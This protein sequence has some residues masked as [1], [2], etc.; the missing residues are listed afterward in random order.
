[1]NNLNNDSTQFDVLAAINFFFNDDA[2]KIMSEQISTNPSLLATQDV[3]RPTFEHGL[4]ELV[5]KEK[6]D[7]LIAELNLYGSFKKIPEDL[8]QTFFITE[9]KMAWN[10]ETRSYRSIGPIGIGSID[11]VSVN[12]KVNGYVEVIHKRTGDVLNIYLEPENGKWFYFSYARG[13]MQALS[14]VTT[15]NDVITKLKPEKRINKEKDKPDFEY[16][17]STD[18]AVKNFLKRMQPAVNEEEK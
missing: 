15:F 2:I 13:L 9:L 17:L 1:M 12:R 10:N 11:K 3:G 6:A 5:G 4:T 7:K 18:R 8:R 14:T 16:I